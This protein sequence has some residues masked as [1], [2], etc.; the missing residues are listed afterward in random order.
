MTMENIE[1]QGATSPE[2]AVA[3]FSRSQARL[4]RKRKAAAI[5][6][7]PG[8][9]SP[10]S[11]SA[12]TRANWR[13]KERRIVAADTSVYLPVDETESGVGCE[14]GRNCAVDVS[15]DA[16]SYAGSKN[17]TRRHR[18][19]DAQP[20]HRETGALSPRTAGW[21]WGT[22]DDLPIKLAGATSSTPSSPPFAGPAVLSLRLRAPV[23]NPAQPPN[24]LSPPRFIIRV[25]SNDAVV[26]APEPFN[27]MCN[28]LRIA[29]VKTLWPLFNTK[30]QPHSPKKKR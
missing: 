19:G 5:V 17:G 11:V 12:E 15:I 26:H 3:H 25:H 23:P 6:H 20:D 22:T 9:R 10:R 8:G 13:R 16:P 30:R 14:Q 18:S 29:F 1:P 24:G 28:G 4:H 21:K 27:N 7:H 2:G